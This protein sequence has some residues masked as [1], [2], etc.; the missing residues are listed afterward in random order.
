MEPFFGSKQRATIT[1]MPLRY[2]NFAFNPTTEE[3]KES[4]K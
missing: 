1:P 2:D 4:S 3:N